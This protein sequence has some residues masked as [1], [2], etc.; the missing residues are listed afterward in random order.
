[1]RD[2]FVAL[3]ALSGPPIKDSGSNAEIEIPE[4]GNPLARDLAEQLR[5]VAELNSSISSAAP[6]APAKEEEEEEESTVGG[7]NRSED[8]VDYARARDGGNVKWY[9]DSGIATCGPRDR[10]SRYSAADLAE[11]KARA[12]RD[13]DGA[14]SFPTDLYDD[15]FT[16]GSLRREAYLSSSRLSRIFSDLSTTTV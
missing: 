3:T 12:L 9:S 6:I 1:M 15:V 2:G 7:L 11:L 16:P 4:T 5:K 14:C 13:T 10:L 8:F